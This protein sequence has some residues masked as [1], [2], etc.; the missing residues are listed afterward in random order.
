MSARSIVVWIQ[1]HMH[2]DDVHAEISAG[3]NLVNDEIDTEFYGSIQ[4]KRFRQPGLSSLP[5]TTCC[6]PFH[7]NAIVSIMVAYK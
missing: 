3:V 5:S 4:W 1:S 2:S 6:A 7:A